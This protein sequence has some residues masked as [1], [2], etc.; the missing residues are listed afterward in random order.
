M[1]TL[2]PDELEELF[3]EPINLEEIYAEAINQWEG[4][5]QDNIIDKTL[6]FYTTLYLQDDILTKVDRASMM[7][8]LEV[9]SPFLDVDVVNFIRRIPANYKYRYGETKFL[10]K[11]SLTGLIPP[12]IIYRSKKGFGAPI[13][14]WFQRGELTWLTLPTRTFLNHNFIEGALKQHM[15]NRMDQRAFLWNIYMLSFMKQ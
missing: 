12:E 7:H 10:L 5:R 15:S 13:G 4:C 1:A 9:R 14:K 8:S 11:R 6:Q 3:H 2:D